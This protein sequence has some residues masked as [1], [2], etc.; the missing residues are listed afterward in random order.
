[1][2]TN[3]KKHKHLLTALAQFASMNQDTQLDGFLTGYA[4]L[5]WERAKQDNERRQQ[6]KREKVR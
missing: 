2:T 3:D 5:E 4:G 6:A 1:M